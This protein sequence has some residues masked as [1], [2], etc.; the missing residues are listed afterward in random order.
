[1][2]LKN[3]TIMLQRIQTVYL[4]IVAA[5]GLALFFLL[6]ICQ[7]GAEFVH[8]RHIRIKCRNAKVSRY[9]VPESGCTYR[10]QYIVTFYYHFLVQEKNVVKSVLHI[11]CYSLICFYLLFGF[12]MDYLWQSIRQPI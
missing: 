7:A 6:T 2:C 8:I 10:N 5:L 11:Q 12:C 4:F 1:M 3:N 9:T